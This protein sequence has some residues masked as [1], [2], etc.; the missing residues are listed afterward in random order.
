[1]LTSTLVLGNNFV[2]GIL[3]RSLASII[4]KVQGMLA[5]VEGHKWSSLPFFLNNDQI[6]VNLKELVTVSSTPGICEKS[7]G[8][9]TNTLLIKSVHKLIH[10][11][12]KCEKERI[13]IGEK[14]DSMKEVVISSVNEAIEEKEIQ[15]GNLTYFNFSNKLCQVLLQEV[16][17]SITQLLDR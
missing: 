9:A 5:R 2:G 1:M 15:N 13:D 3:T 7:S 12:L 14:L 11:F 16:H 8:K 6:L 17:L 4:S 10:A